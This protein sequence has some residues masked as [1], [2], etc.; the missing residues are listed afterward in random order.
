M[1]E[2]L[3][4]ANLQIDALQAKLPISSDEIGLDV[5]NHEVRGLLVDNQINSV[6]KENASG[7]LNRSFDLTINDPIDLSATFEGSENKT[8]ACIFNPPAAAAGDHS[9]IFSEGVISIVGTV[10]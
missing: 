7:V 6:V 8:S 9:D 4:A 10:M 2:H 1:N 5:V 3:N